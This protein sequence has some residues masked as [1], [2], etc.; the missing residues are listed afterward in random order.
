MNKPNPLDILLGTDGQKLQKCRPASLV[1]Y[2]QRDLRSTL[3]LLSSFKLS[4]SK[5][6]NWGLLVLQNFN[7]DTDVELPVF[8]LEMLNNLQVKFL[9]CEKV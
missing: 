3:K 4:K 9:S 1:R 6:Y 8:P 5:K 7:P 2:I